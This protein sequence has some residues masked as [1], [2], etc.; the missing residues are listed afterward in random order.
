MKRPLMETGC[1]LLLGAALLAGVGCDPTASDNTIIVTPA[2]TNI[3]LNTHIRLT[4]SLPG[5]ADEDRTLYYPLEWSVKHPSIGV[6][7]HTQ[8]DSAVYRHHAWGPANIVMVR[9]QAGSEGFAGVGHTGVAMALIVTPDHAVIG[10]NESLTL[11]ASLPDGADE[12]VVLHYP[13]EW[14]VEHPAL[15]SIRRASGHS[16]VYESTLWSGVNVVTVR[17]QAGAEGL[18]TVEQRRERE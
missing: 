15:G 7:L 4:A 14:S 18:A 16:A 11:T 1:G 5:G 6:V 9:D 17:D 8:G 3:A 2:G 10:P 12:D 13:L